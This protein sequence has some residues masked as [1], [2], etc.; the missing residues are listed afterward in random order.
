MDKIPSI[1]ISYQVALIGQ[2]QL[3]L[4]SFIDRDCSLDD[5][6]KL[7]DKL[8]D[9]GERQY[10]YGKIEEI[11]L[12]LKQE[13]KNAIDQQVRIEDTDAKIKRDWNG[14]NRKGDLKMTSAQI[15]QQKRDYAV[16]EGIKLRMASLKAALVEWEAK[17]AG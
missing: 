14:G 10:A 9:A 3:V 16:A 15:E 6:N 11:K 17:L 2:R 4:Q 7:L 5:F 13:E 1:G 8:R 12:N